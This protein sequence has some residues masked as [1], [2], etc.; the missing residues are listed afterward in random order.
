MRCPWPAFRWV[1]TCT[2]SKCTPVR[3]RRW[4]A[5]PATWRNWWP[6]RAS[7]PWCACPPAKCATCLNCLATIGQVGNVEH[8]NISIGKAGRKRQ[9]GC[10]PDGARFRHEP[11][12]PPARRRRGQEPGGSSRPCHPVGQAR[13]GYKTR[14][15]HA[16]SDKFIVKT[17]HEIR[18]RAVMGRSVKKGPFVQPVLLKRVKR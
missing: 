9:L 15:H 5:A 10:R 2:I 3:A 12:R 8:E 18:R 13:Y 14:K 6:R 1:P 7:T 4:C 16:R 17:R 11:R